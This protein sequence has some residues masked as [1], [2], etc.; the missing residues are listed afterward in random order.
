MSRPAR[1]RRRAAA[2][3]PSS[4]AGPARSG[5]AARGLPARC[6]PTIRHLASGK[7]QARRVTAWAGMRRA[8]A[9]RVPPQGSMSSL[10][11]PRQLQSSLHLKRHDAIRCSRNPRR[12]R[13][14]T[15]L[16]AIHARHARARRRVRSL[17][18][19]LPLLN[20]SAMPPCTSLEW[21]PAR[22]TTDSDLIPDWRLGLAR[23]CGRSLVHRSTGLV[24]WPLPVRF[25]RS[26]TSSAQDAGH[27]CHGRRGT[28]DPCIETFRRGT[29]AF[30]HPFRE[31]SGSP[32]SH[33]AYRQVNRC[34]R[35]RRCS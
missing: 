27:G 8:Q 1:R 14:P 25:P 34:E 16:Q 20:S 2:P 9:R 33:L 21:P 29:C 15:H 35:R 32:L 5:P 24:R 6:R 31:C 18:L 23:A 3:A 28:H 10:G 11:L 30:L 13:S 4:L 17:A 7:H 22:H 26:E 12:P 19:N